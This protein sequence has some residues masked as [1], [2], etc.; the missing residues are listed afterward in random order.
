VLAMVRTFRKMF[1]APPF[2]VSWHRFMQ[3][4]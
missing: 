2:S 3:L 1:D 4:R